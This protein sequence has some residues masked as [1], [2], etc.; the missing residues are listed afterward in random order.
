[1]SKPFFHIE[2]DTVANRKANQ[3]K[4]INYNPKNKKKLKYKI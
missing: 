3:L 2:I 1:M 4:T